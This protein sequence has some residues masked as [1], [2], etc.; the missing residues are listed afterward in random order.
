MVS[1]FLGG[2]TVLAVMALLAKNGD[3]RSRSFYRKFYT[4]HTFNLILF[5]W[6]LLGE[7][8]AWILTRGIALGY[9][10][11]HPAT[12]RVVR[13]NIALLDPRRASHVGACRLFVNQAECFSNYGRL[14]ISQP[15]EVMNF[16][17][18]REGFSHLKA[19]HEAGKGCFLVTGHF[20][21]FEL[22]GLVMA[23]LGFSMTA[24]TLPEPS[25]ALTQW[26]SDFRA[27]WGVKTIVVRDDSFSVLEIVR[28]LREGGF[29]ASLAD[30]PYDENSIPVDCPHGQI[31]FS[32]GPVLLSLLAGC[33]II[34]VGIM[35]RADGKYDIEA[36]AMIEPHWL[37]EGRNATLTHYTR[38]IASVLVPMFA[39]SPE[40]WYHYSP[41]RYHPP[42]HE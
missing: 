9:A 34:P 28:S 22:G 7:T 2:A 27:R 24:L 38:E 32:K 3:Y 16:I 5:G 23:Q 10:L 12:L 1:V 40:Q 29:I 37:P 26:R 11:T 15:G 18:R 17:G 6:R 21:F 36:G 19:A 14:A 42:P 20:G 31:L 35:R 8:G 13:S 30:R 41:L 4:S 25:Q 33:P 39:R